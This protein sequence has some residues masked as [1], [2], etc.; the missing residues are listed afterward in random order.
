MGKRKKQINDSV[1]ALVVNTI[2]FASSVRLL[3]ITATN[4]AILFKLYSYMLKLKQHLLSATHLKIL[5]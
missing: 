4:I 3:V 2:R 1:S 5:C